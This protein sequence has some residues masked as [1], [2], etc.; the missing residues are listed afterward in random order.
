MPTRSGGTSSGSDVVADDLVKRNHALVKYEP[1]EERIR[2]VYATTVPR[3]ITR[4]AL[5]STERS[6]SGLAS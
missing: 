2:D 4:V 6:S 3:S 5:A 1:P